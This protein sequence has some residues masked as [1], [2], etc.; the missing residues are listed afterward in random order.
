MKKYKKKGSIIF[1]NSIYGILGQDLNLYQDTNIQPN[2]IYSLI[3]GGLQNF[4]KNMAS[5]Y[6]TKAIRVNSIITGGVEGHIAGSKKKQ[7]KN[8]KLNY[9]KKTFLKR[10]ADPKEIASGVLFL[11]SDAS[12]YIT[13]SNLIIDGGRTIWWKILKKNT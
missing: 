5:F 4:V 7:S 13:G 2:P 6:G 1:L 3:K 12:S 9:A 8:F 10:M 11:S